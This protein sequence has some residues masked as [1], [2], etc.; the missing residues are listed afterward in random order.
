MC[1]HRVEFRRVT[2]A[3]SLRQYAK[4]RGVSVEAVSR[5]IQRRRLSDSV[6]LVNGV[7]RI[8][9]PKLADEEWARNTQT[10]KRPRRTKPRIVS[11]RSEASVLARAR[12]ESLD[13]AHFSAREN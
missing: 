11:R 5:A 1:G 8:Q 2:K 6:V 7:P 12:V 3:L 13:E 9:N 4:R 10:V